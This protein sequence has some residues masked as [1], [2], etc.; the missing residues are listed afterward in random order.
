ML[1]L[2]KLLRS[3]TEEDTKLEFR[4]EDTKPELLV[5]VELE[6]HIPTLVQHPTQLTTLPTQLTFPPHQ[7]TRLLDMSQEEVVSDREAELDT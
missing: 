1:S 5:E 3:K 7:L 2:L 4:T 6:T